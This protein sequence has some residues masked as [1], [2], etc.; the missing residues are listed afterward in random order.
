MKSKSS[1]KPVY[2]KQI[3]AAA[4]DARSVYNQAQ[5]G[6]LN[7]TNAVQSG[8]PG[9]AEKAF[10]T[11]PTIDAA[12]GFA[13]DT[14]GGKYLDNNP[15]VDEMARNAREG[16]GDSINSYFGKIGRVGS[17]LHM[18]DLGR[19]LS[20]AELGVRSG[21]YNSERGLQNNAAA[22]VP[23]LNQAQ[24][25]GV[26]ALLDAANVGANIPYVGSNNLSS[27]IGGLLGQYTNTTQKQGMGGLLAGIAGAGLSGWAGGGFKG[28]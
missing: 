20:E 10:G 14:I 22:M 12:Q 5:P 3:E 16:V 9:L 11:D 13:R 28:I 8:I 23:G 21:I 19:G 26:G 7:I 2:S 27:N 15:Y 1:T 25:N 24:Y 4:A 17:G 18:E 6:L